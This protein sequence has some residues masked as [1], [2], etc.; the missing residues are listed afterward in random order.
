[1]PPSHLYIHVPFCAR[2]CSYCDFSIAVR[3]TAP[4]DEYLGAL[5]T[6]AE[7]VIRGSW[8]LDTLYLGGGTPSRLGGGGIARL[9]AAIRERALINPGAELT[10]EANPDDV[11]AETAAAW[12]DAGINRVSLGAQSFDDR[13]LE[14]MHRVHTADQTRQ[15]IQIL[16]GA[17]I[18]DVSVDLIFNLPDHLERNWKSDVEQA[19]ALE[20]THVSL[21]G[22]T[23][24]HHTPIARWA[25]RGAIVEGTD[26]QYAE[27]FLYA[28]NAMTA[29]GFDHYEVSNFARPGRSS[30]H[31]SA[32][33]TGAP[34]AGLGP[35]AH[36]FDGRFRRWNVPAY[37]DWVKRLGRGESVI[38]GEEQLTAENRDAEKVYL[39]LRTRSGLLLDKPEPGTAE[40]WIAAGWAE[41]QGMRLTL[42]PTGWLRLDSLAAALAAARDR[43]SIPA[44]STTPSHC[45][46]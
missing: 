34:Y 1:M 21:Y 25:D 42:T 40:P 26:S 46:I 23:V 29:A 3:S 36:A 4:V 44:L 17:G 31:N 11:T 19:L 2:R 37:A 15:A 35:S 13:V 39:G 22:L 7:R 27:E 24:E 20:P 5:R 28:H 14:W 43:R 18:D 16:R 45:Y 33:W 38:A 6:E 10:L 32:Y 30:R 41:L 9:L 12:I 8:P